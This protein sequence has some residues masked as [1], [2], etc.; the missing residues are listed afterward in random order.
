MRKKMKKYAYIDA[1]KLIFGS[2]L[3]WTIA[4]AQIKYILIW[5]INY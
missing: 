3:Y 4:G 5:P 2:V 1:Y